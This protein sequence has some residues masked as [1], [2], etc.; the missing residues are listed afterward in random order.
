MEKL[1]ITGVNGLLGQKLLTQAA[2]KYS[3]I[4][5]DLHNEPFNKKINF[6][7]VKLDLT[8]RNAVKDMILTEYPHYLI[9]TAAM[10]NVDACETEKEKCWKINVEAVNNIV[11]ATRKIGT[12]IVHLST[13]YVFD[14]SDGPYG[15]EASPS[16]LGYYGKSKLASENSLRASDLD[17]AIVRTM[18]LYGEAE[19]VR[20][21]FVT[22]LVSALRQGNSVTIVNDQF[23]NPTLADDLAA[24]ILRIIQ[25]QKWDLFHISGS[26]FIDRYQF[27]L[28]IADVYKLNKSLINQISTSELKQAAPR[29]LKSG[30]II[31]KT[32]NELEIHMSNVEEGLRK[33]RKQSKKIIFFKS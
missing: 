30:F 3:V 33:Q 17:F 24:A 29:P 21:N 23:G 22:W 14:G 16:P 10:T 5:I 13:D 1:L 31:D 2:S 4:G 6:K 28:K 9:N 7:Y 26:E 20:P 25:L 32:E 18:I 8:D 12:K 11:Y 19:D 15:E 27:A